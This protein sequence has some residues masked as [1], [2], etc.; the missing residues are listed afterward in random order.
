MGEILGVMESIFFWI[1]ENYFKI[2]T[3]SVNITVNQNIIRFNE[4]EGLEVWLHSFLML[5]LHEC[6]GSISCPS[7]FTNEEKHHH[8]R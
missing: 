4:T 8:I 1:L 6:E 5:A 7:C 2:I 3:T